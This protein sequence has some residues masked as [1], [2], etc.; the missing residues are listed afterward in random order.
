M[1]NI[2]GSSE[3]GHLM[4]GAH[5]PFVS[6]DIGSWK[7][8]RPFPHTSVILKPVETGHLKRTFQVHVSRDDPRLAYG[9]ISPEEETWDTGDVIQESTPVSEWYELLYRN[10]D[11]LVHV[12]GKFMFVLQ[13]IRYEF[14]TR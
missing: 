7:L 8:V 12:S 4:I 14:F 2:Y 1:T 13:E 10:D 9:V 3:T 6:T 5:N 11:I